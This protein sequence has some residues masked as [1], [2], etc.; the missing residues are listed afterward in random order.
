VAWRFGLESQQFVAPQIRH[1]RRWTQVLPIST[2][3]A[4]TS[5]PGGRAGSI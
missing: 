1:C 5:A 3:A 4:Q 2:Q